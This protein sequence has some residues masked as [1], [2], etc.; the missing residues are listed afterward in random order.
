MQVGDVAKYP[1]PFEGAGI[2]CK[3]EEEEGEDVGRLLKQGL[4]YVQK[5]RRR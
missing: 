4:L 1:P 3:A 2:L 5:G